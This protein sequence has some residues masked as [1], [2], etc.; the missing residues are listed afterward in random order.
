MDTAIDFIKKSILILD[1]TGIGKNITP[2]EASYALSSLNSILESW[3]E[4]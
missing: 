3:S 2:Q 1:V 4:E